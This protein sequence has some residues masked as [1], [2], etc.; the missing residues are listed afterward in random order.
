MSQALGTMEWMGEWTKNSLPWALPQH[1]LRSVCACVCVC[2]H[3][4]VHVCARHF[5]N[6]CPCSKDGHTKA[7][8]GQLTCLL[9]TKLKSCLSE[10]K[11]HVLPP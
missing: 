6:R 10:V 4:Q 8:N 11:A 2:V 5:K 9:Q 3:V 1:A 7:L